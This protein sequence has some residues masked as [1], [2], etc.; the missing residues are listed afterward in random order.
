MKWIA[1]IIVVLLLVIAF[2]VVRSNIEENARRDA[3]RAA[4]RQFCQDHP[5]DTDCGNRPSPDS[6]DK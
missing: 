6:D 3:A 1:S 4:D 5:E 2:A